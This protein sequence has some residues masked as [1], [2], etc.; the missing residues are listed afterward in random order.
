M[1]PTSSRIE[2]GDSTRSGRVLPCRVGHTGRRGEPYV[3]GSELVT[4]SLQGRHVCRAV[5]HELLGILGKSGSDQLFAGLPSAD[6]HD[7]ATRVTKGASDGERGG[8]VSD[9]THDDALSDHL[10][11]GATTVKVVTP[12]RHFPRGGQQMRGFG[13]D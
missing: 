6:E 9:A 13:F 1:R 4:E 7:L 10:P 3:L 5:H 8:F 2:R 11:D 12:R